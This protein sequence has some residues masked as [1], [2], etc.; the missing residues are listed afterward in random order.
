MLCKVTQR[1]SF[2]RRS[3][4]PLALLL[5]CTALLLML[6]GC[7]NQEERVLQ[8]VSERLEPIKTHDETMLAQLAENE[9]FIELE[10]YGVDPSSFLESYLSGFDYSITSVAIDGKQAQVVVEICSK[11]YAAFMTAF[12]QGLSAA[13]TSDEYAY[14]D[15]EEAAQAIGAILMDALDTLEPSY[16]SLTLQLERVKGSWQFT[17]DADLELERALIMPSR[18]AVALE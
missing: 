18:Q 8:A 16:A 15:S 10:A 5:V 3:L 7:G 11:N 13:Q 1:F 12:N 14:V 4:L 6:S 17:E 9:S 2:Y